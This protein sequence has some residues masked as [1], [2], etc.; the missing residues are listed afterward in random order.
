LN[1]VEE[2][3]GLVIIGSPSARAKFLLLFTKKARKTPSSRN[4]DDRNGVLR[5]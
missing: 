1:D 2:D 5:E 3:G 4:I